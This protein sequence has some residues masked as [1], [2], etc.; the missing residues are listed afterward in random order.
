MVVRFVRVV[1]RSERESLHQMKKSSPLVMNFKFQ[2]M[3]NC[4]DHR[5]VRERLLWHE[6]SV[7][8]V[9]TK[10]PVTFTPNIA[11]RIVKEESLPTLTYWAWRRV[12]MTQHEYS[13]LQSVAVCD[14]P[15]LHVDLR[16]RSLPSGHTFSMWGTNDNSKKKTVTRPVWSEM[17][18]ILI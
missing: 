6:T 17:L 9:L 13:L 5:A 12:G 18:G 15:L 10:W 2:S 7:Y 1:L 14:L 8:K 3:L 16:D 4:Y 11:S